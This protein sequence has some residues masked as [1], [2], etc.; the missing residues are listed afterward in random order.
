[1]GQRQFLKDLNIWG[2]T[3]VSRCGSILHY[4]I[5]CLLKYCDKVLLMQ[6]N[7][8]EE[9]REIILKYKEKYPDKIVL[10]ETGFPYAT[11]VQDK[12]DRGLLRRFKGLQGPIREKVFEYLREEHKKKKIDILIFPDSDEVFSDYL[13]ILLEEFWKRKDIKAVTMKPVDVFGDMMTIHGRSMTGHTRIM[14]FF[15]ELTAIPYRTACYYRPLTK[16]DRIGSNRVTIHLCTLSKEKMAWRIKHWKRL[17]KDS[18]ALWRLSKD[19]RKM[20]P[21]EIRDVLNREPDMNVEEYLR[22]GDKRVPV[23]ID[24]AAKA[25]R[26]AS[27]M[28]DKM[29][30]RH[31]LAFGTCLGVVRDKELIKWDWDIDLIM[32]GEDLDK[33]NKQKVLENGFEGI[34]VKRDIPKWKK[35]GQESKDLYT[36]TIS[37][38]K[39]GVRV[40]IDPAYI[41]ADGKSRIILKGRKREKFCAKHPAS[42]FGPLPHIG[43]NGEDLGL[44]QIAAEYRGKQYN[45]PSPVGDYLESN[46]GKNWDVPAYGPMP[47]RKRSCMSEEYECK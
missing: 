33:F 9:T 41:S 20:S 25:L 32:L 19:V 4:T 26:E 17:L 39:Y 44:I 29:G 8:N 12:V 35:N 22:G 6:D 7:I 24:N 2:A 31:F 38:H 40:D 23:G 36:R 11:K 10:A 42:L 27:D 45:I 18:E 46:Y 47:W 28:L 37:F 5:P 14:K 15:P 13:P 16:L 34:K 21:D 43:K 3:L 30:I 1:M